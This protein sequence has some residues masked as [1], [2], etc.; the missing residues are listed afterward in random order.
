M[1]LTIPEPD[2]RSTEPRPQEAVV[3]TDSFASFVAT[4][5]AQGHALREESQSNQG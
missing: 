3:F 5:V 2:E 1:Y 4:P